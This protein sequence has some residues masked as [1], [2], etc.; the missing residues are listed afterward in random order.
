VADARTG[1]TERIFDQRE[2]PTTRAYVS[3]QAG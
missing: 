3:G 2:H 1:P